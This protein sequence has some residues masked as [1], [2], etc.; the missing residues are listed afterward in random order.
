MVAPW[1]RSTG[2]CECRGQECDRDIFSI[3]V[4]AFHTSGKAG[5]WCAGRVLVPQC[6]CDI[7]QEMVD[8]AQ[9]GCVRLSQLQVHDSSVVNVDSGKMRR[10]QRAKRPYGVPW[11]WAS[12]RTNDGIPAQQT[13]CSFVAS[14]RGCLADEKCFLSCHLTEV[15]QKTIM[16]TFS[17]KHWRGGSALTHTDKTS[18]SS[19]D[20]RCTGQKNV[21]FPEH[22]DGKLRR[23]EKEVDA[24]Q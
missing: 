10:R 16:I 22:K 9:C 20:G 24:Q 3:L 2:R 19:G 14:S 6:V 11:R 12:E 7:A 1:T 15:L 21:R 17:F 13:W 18:L 5:P 23:P 8:R 4:R